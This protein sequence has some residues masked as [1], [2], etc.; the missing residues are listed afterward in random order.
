VAA[1]CPAAQSARRCGSCSGRGAR[2]AGR[3]VGA[4]SRGPCALAPHTLLG[5]QRRKRLSPGRACLCCHDPAVAP[6]RAGAVGPVCQPFPDKPHSRDRAT[7][8]I[9]PRMNHQ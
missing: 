6:S 3:Q 4:L 8:T 5:T 9:H 2:M 1:R 7:R